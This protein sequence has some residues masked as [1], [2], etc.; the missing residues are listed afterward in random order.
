M[1]NW[2]PQATAKSSSCLM[3]ILH[4]T[5]KAW[6]R[7]INKLIFFKNLHGNT[8]FNLGKKITVD[9]HNSALKHINKGISSDF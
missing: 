3:K 8:R 6:C 7:Q 9:Y 4:D 2:I 5:S 1:G